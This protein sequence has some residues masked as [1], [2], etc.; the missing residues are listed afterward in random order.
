MISNIGYGSKFDTTPL[1]RPRA[2]CSRS[3]YFVF[4]G[5][6]T[7]GFTWTYFCLPETKGVA[8]EDSKFYRWL[9]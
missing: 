8:L 5:M 3:A 4:A 7:L 6:L 1:D 2:D 9:L